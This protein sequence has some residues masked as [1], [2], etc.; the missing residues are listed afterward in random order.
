MRTK[1]GSDMH[2]RVTPKMETEIRRLAKDTGESIATVVRRLVR[3]G[4]ESEARNAS[5]KLAT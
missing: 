4:I 1:I 5:G 3:A 2:F